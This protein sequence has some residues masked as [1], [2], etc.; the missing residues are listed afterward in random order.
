MVF[1]NN[2]FVEVLKIS[3]FRNLWLSQ[4]ISQTFLQL[5][6]FS[7]MLRVYDLTRSSSAVSVV[8]FLTTIPN[9]FLGALA[10][11]LVDHWGRKPVMFF[12]HFLRAIA[13]VAVF[14][15]AESPGRIYTLVFLISSITQF[16]FPA[17]AGII[18]ELV[19][20]KKLLL[21]ANSLFS[22]TFFGTVIAGNILAGPALLFLGHH[23]TFLLVAAAF[24]LASLFTFQLPGLPVW[25]FRQN[26]EELNINEMFTDFMG[27]IDH[28]YKAPQ[29]RS[30]I[31]LL[32][33]SQISIGILGVVAPGFA[34][35]VLHLPVT[36][37]SLLV[38]APAA[39]GM[40]MG[41]VVLGQ[42]FRAVSKRKLIEIGFLAAGAGLVIY[43]LNNQVWLSVILLLILGAAN[44]FLDIPVNTL[45]QENTPESVRSRVYGVISSV[46]GLA[47]IF[48][49]VISGALADMVGVQT[50]MF[51]CGL[52]IFS[53]AVLY[54]KNNHAGNFF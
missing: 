4:L 13:V 16:F 45:I 36:D 27:G 12:C 1:K 23:W 46:I 5:L 2:A 52:T 40:A 7:L 35:Q 32:G 15:S 31:C 10:G 33:I 42:F 29:V 44:A 22:I 19:K 3:S 39:A 21:T 51:L 38:M 50:V 9:I 11:V 47:G 20:D 24:I 37:V 41:A 28:L 30:G 26:R 25:R 34:D 54:N 53:L 6:F 49:I 18:Y 43:S 48:P 8:V 17:E 14:A